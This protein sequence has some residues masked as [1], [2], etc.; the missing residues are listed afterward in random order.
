MQADLITYVALCLVIASFAK[1][2]SR[3][4]TDLDAQPIEIQAHRNHCLTR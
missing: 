1:R 2:L 3:L 4:A